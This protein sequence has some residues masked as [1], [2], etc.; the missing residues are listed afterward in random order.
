MAWSELSPVI[1]VLP[2]LLVL[3]FSHFLVEGFSFLSADST[4]S[5][6]ISH[7]SLSFVL[8]YFFCFFGELVGWEEEFLESL[9][10]SLVSLSVT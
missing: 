8:S 2:C 3:A 10:S 1:S 4:S 6:E 7:G 9:C 5:S